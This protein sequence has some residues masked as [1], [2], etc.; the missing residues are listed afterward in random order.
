MLS[1][2]DLISGFKK[3]EIDQNKP[4]IL[5]A[6]LSS[7]GEVR[8]GAD[9]LLGATLASFHSIMSPTFTYKS[10]IIPET[11]PENNGLEYRSGHTLNKMAEFYTQDMPADRLMGILAEKIRLH[12]LAQ[13]STHPI[14][15]FSGIHL[16]EAI[17]RQSLEEPLAPIEWLIDHQGYVL[18]MGV[19]HTVNTSIHLAE[20]KAGRKSFIRWALTTSAI[21]ECPGF[22]G[23]S[24]GF[25]QTTDHLTDITKM[26]K[27]GDA[28]IMAIPLK[29]MVEILVPII[30][31]DPFAILCEKVTCPRCQSIRNQHNNQT[32]E[33]TDA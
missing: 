4:V 21:Y 8:G 27:I 33:Q 2:R 1:Y 31:S 22:P 14:L 24:D 23:C 19:D 18:L 6:S 32:S 25:I 10:M 28:T 5:H 20:Q 13:R 30:Q 26:T 12:P 9:T 11:G 3:L 29:E 15:S 7:F 17:D 16:S